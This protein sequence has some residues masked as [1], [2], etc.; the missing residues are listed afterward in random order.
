MHQYA[1][2]HIY[3]KARAAMRRLTKALAERPWF[4]GLYCRPRRYIAESNRPLS[5]VAD[6]WNYEFVQDRPHAVARSGR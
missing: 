2:M 6:F 4:C 3:C 5:R 1:R